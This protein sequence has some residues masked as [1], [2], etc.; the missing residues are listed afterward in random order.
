V[1]RAQGS[2]R[3]QVAAEV[4][5]AAEPEQRLAPD[6]AQDCSVHRVARMKTKTEAEQLRE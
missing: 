4:E 3:E 5:E 2:E 1:E 6:L